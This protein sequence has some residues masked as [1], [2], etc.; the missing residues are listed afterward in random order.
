MGSIPESGRSP[1]E[2]NGNPLWHSCLGN[3]IDRGAWRG[4]SL[5]SQGVR[6]NWSD[7]A[8]TAHLSGILENSPYRPANWGLPLGAT[9]ATRVSSGWKGTWNSQG[10]DHSRKR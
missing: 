10:T 1:G 3:L 9:E 4:Q 8:H 5:V 2:G 6:H 7:G